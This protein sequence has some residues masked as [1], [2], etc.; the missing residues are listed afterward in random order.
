MRLAAGG[1]ALFLITQQ[2]D[3][4]MEIRFRQTKEIDFK[5]T[6]TITREAFWDLYK[7]GCDEH[8]ILNK[9]RRSKCYVRGLDLLAVE[10][11]RIIG[12]IICTKA[13]VTDAKKIEHPVLCVGPFSILNKYQGKGFGSKLMEYCIHKAGELGY[14]AMILFGNPTYYHQFG[15]RN[16]AEY[17]ITTKEGMNFEPF[18]AKELQTNG[19]KEIQ[20]KFYE[21]E[22]FLVD[23]AELDKFEEQFPF[24]EKHIT[25]TQLKV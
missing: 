8:L 19:L 16:A 1:S 17:G 3:G 21:D 15:F 22:S 13:K 10:G 12:H 9:I 18:M 4:T 25:D 24:K 14:A 6:E 2:T 7:P 23:A 5:E 11:E 20:G